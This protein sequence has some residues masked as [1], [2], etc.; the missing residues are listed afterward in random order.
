[1]NDEEG[2]LGYQIFE[3]V[4]AVQFILETVAIAGIIFIILIL[5][6]SKTLK[7]ANRRKNKE[8]K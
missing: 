3:E 5:G 8:D 1:M 2:E 4:K 7:D 6:L